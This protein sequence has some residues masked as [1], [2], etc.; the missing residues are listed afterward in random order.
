VLY[1]FVTL[2][3]NAGS[4]W[5]VSVFAVPIGQI[6]AFLSSRFLSSLVGCIPRRQV[7]S[8]SKRPTFPLPQV[9]QLRVKA[10]AKRHEKLTASC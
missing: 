9:G 8:L 1:I 2:L 5:D 6:D 10:R 4:M 7:H 3:L